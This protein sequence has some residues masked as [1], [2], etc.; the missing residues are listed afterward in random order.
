M[1]NLNLYKNLRGM[2][3]IHHEVLSYALRYGEN[4]GISFDLLVEGKR[5]RVSMKFDDFDSL[6][7]NGVLKCEKVAGG[8]EYFYSTV[9]SEEINDQGFSW[10]KDKN[11]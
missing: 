2:G 4:G 9:G 10:S 7:R 8:K 1:E 5:A 3:Y 11:D 6:T